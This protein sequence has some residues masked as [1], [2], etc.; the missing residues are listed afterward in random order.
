MLGARNKLGLTHEQIDRCVKI[1]QVLGGD[2]HRLLD[3][4]EAHRYGSRTRF[5]ERRGAMILG[6]DVLPGSGQ[7]PN[8]RMSRLACLAHELAHAERFEMGYNR[9]FDYPDALLDEAET[10]I[11]ASFTPVLSHATG[12]SWWMTQGSGW[13]TGLP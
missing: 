8:A 2:V 11:H 10:S 3:V 13:W 7:T 6:A 5:D 9:P 1:W 12:R 4:G